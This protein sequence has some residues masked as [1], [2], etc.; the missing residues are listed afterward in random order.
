MF[1]GAIFILK[2]HMAELEKLAALEISSDE[3]ISLNLRSRLKLADSL[4]SHLMRPTMR[5]VSKLDLSQNSLSFLPQCFSRYLPALKSLNLSNNDFRR[6]PSDKLEG[7]VHLETLDMCRNRITEWEAGDCTR[8]SQIRVFKIASNMISSVP[9]NVDTMSQLQVLILGSECVGGNNIQS[10]PSSIGQ[11]PELRELDGSHNQLT[12]L[13]VDIG[14]LQNLK[15]LN[16]AYNELTHL[17]RS[18]AYLP[19]LRSLNVSK[20]QLTEVPRELSYLISLQ[21]LDVSCNNLTSLN[22]EVMDFLIA[23]GTSVMLAGNPWTTLNPLYRT[24]SI[25]QNPHSTNIPS[26]VEMA[27]RAIINNSVPLDIGSL[28][29]HLLRDICHRSGNCGVCAGA[30]IEEYKSHARHV[31]YFLGHENLLRY[32]SVCSRKC[33]EQCKKECVMNKSLHIS[34]TKSLAERSKWKRQSKWKI[35]QGRNSLDW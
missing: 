20:N 21:M 34:D 4:Q 24:R 5:Y 22:S 15:E 19:M 35:A 28:P 7:C 10:L 29:E 25:S 9:D 3:P 12:S 31:K 6:I 16:L 30:F 2:K 14:L 1:A 13:P 26:L 18:I 33:F 11:L 27:S 32:E 23:H 17:S 8:L